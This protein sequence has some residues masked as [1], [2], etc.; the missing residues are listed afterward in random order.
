MNLTTEE[1][2]INDAIKVRFFTAMRYLIVRSDITGIAN[3]KAFAEAIG[4]PQPNMYR[5]EAWAGRAVPSRFLVMMVERYGLHA[6]W[7]LTGKGPMW[8]KGKEIH[9]GK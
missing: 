2:E 7:L 9:L 3:K 4:W 1:Q 6:N 8:Q 5:A